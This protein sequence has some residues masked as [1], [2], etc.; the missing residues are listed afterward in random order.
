LL[1]AAQDEIRAKVEEPLED[2][3]EIPFIEP[4]PLSPL[5]PQM[6]AVK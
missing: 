5:G 4:D 6:E 3:A 1:L 2:G